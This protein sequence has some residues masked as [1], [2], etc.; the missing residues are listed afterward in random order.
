MDK[1]RLGIVGIGNM[2]SAHAQNL[3]EGKVKDAEL[4]AVCDIRASRRAWAKETL[5][6]VHIY[7]DITAMLESGTCDG[8]IVATPHYDH[9]T[10]G[11]AVLKSGHHLLVEKP[12]GV[13]AKDV[14]ELNS[15]AA[16]TDRVFTIMYNQRTNPVYQKVKAMMDG[17]ELGALIRVNWTI[18][19]WFRSERYYNLGGWRATWSGEGGGVLLNQCPHQIDLLQWL[20]GMPKRVRAFAGYGKYHDIE[21]ED[22]VTAYLEYE[23]GA[24]GTF[25]T[26]TGESPGTNRLEISGEHGKLTVEDGKIRFIKNAVSVLEYSKSTEEAFKEPEHQVID[27]EVQGEETSHIG[28]MAS[29]VAAIR[30]GESQ[31]SPGLEGI[32]GLRLTNAMY[33]SSWTHQM[34]DVPVDGDAFLKLLNNRRATSK[35]RKSVVDAVIDLK[36]SH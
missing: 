21:V 19:N 2:G 30:H 12:V 5:E 33:M 22:D 14:E 4:T 8:I 32:H 9:P 27:I 26:T 6:G 10:M 36:G 13:F 1:V 23:N 35:T 31:I 7:E 18:T 25:I 11:M 15:L 17:G 29:F 3:F 34:V 16:S 24:T 28:I 20:C